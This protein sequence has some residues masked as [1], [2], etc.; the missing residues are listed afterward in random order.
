MTA[1]LVSADVVE[2][3]LTRGY[4]A[5]VDAADAWVLQWKWGAR[6]SGRNIYAFRKARREN[7]SWA[8]LSLHRVIMGDACEGLP[9]DHMDG[10]GLNN[11]RSNLRAV[12]A[13]KNARNVGGAPETNATSG[14]MGIS[15]S[16]EGHWVAFIR[17]GGANIYLGAYSSMEAAAVARAQEEMRRWGAEPRRAQE[18]SRWLALNIDPADFRVQPRSPRSGVRGVYRIS[19]ADRWGANISIGGELRYLGCF[20]T[21]DEAVAA[22]LSAEASLCAGSVAA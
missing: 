17:D 19:N 4:V 14:I 21:K 8:Y 5:I 20:K 1:P 13:I 6:Q 2:V 16:R 10:D 12:P 15:R 7:G 22:R 9:V 11:R 18:L 3:P